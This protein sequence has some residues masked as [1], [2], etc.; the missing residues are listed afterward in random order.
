MSINTLQNVTD[1]KAKNLANAFGNIAYSRSD[2]VVL[3]KVL[4][5][6]SY[7]V[8]AAADGYHR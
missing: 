4:A 3:I 5:N 8:T 2:G 1:G 6:K 7:I